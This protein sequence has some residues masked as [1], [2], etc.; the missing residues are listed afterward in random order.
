MS[1]SEWWW[2]LFPMF[3]V[4]GILLVWIDRSINRVGQTLHEIRRLL[5]WSARKQGWLSPEE[6]SERLWSSE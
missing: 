1:A 2:S 4:L 6:K 5:E 3:V